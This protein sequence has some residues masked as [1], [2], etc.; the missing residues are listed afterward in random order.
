VSPSSFVS[1]ENDWKTPTAARHL[2]D[3]VRSGVGAPPSA[4]VDELPD[5]LARLL[6]RVEETEHAHRDQWGCWEYGF[7]ENFTRGRLWVPEVDLWVAA[8][9][10]RLAKEMQLEPL[11]PEG[12]SFA[13]CLTHDVDMV[14]RRWTTSQHIRS[15]SVALKG[16]TGDAGEGVARR[17]AS[18]AVRAVGRIPYFGVSRAPDATDTLERCVELE[19]S[20]GVTGSYLLTV[21]PTRQKTIYDAVYA[22][23]DRCRFRGRTRRVREIAR[24]LQQEGFDVGLHAG[25]A[26]ATDLDDFRYEKEVVEEYIDGDVVSCRQHYLHWDVDA[27]PRIQSE[28]GI[29]VDTTIGF[30]RNIGF[31]A[32]TALPYRLFDL[33]AGEPLDVL[34]VPLIIQ[35][36]PLLSANALEL[37]V[38]LAQETM[39]GFIECI[40][41]TGGVVTLLFHPHSLAQPAYLRLYTWALDYARDRGAWVANL[42]AIRSWWDERAARLESAHSAP[43]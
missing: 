29:R 35:E 43:G 19:Q 32:G 8:E 13:L 17:R 41:E 5:E 37:D 23:S 11:W 31:R 28:A 4:A 6:L 30:N 10:R 20:R 36:S 21:Y 1:R 42:R 12:A 39:K 34:E 25:Y 38:P 27:T 9:R 33:A 3:V 22:G 18:A 14:A 40:A 16:A 15:L 7:S 26:S 24:E 2:A